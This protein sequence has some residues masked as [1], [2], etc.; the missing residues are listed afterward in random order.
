MWFASLM[1]YVDAVRQMFRAQGLECVVWERWI[2]LSMSQANHMQI[3]ICSCATRSSG[4]PAFQALQETSQ[5]LLNGVEFKKISDPT[6]IAE[7]MNDNAET[8]YLY[9]EL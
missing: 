8:P 9:F 1:K 5:K 6:E 3:Q 4:L 2:P 7:H